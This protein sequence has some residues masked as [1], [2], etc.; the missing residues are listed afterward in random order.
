MRT[1]IF[2]PAKGN[3]ERIKNKNIF[4]LDGMPLFLITLDKIIKSGLFDEV[5]LDSESPEIHKMAD[6]LNCLRLH[7]DPA[8]ATNAADGNGMFLN[9]VRH[10]EADIIV[11]I[12]C[13]SPFIAPGTLKKGLDVLMSGSEY[14]S[15]VLVRKDKRYEWTESGPGYDCAHIPNSVDLPWIYSETMG[16]YM[17][18][19]EAALKTG[20]RIGEKPYL[21]EASP[22]EAVD[23]NDPED[24]PLAEAIA[25]G[26]R[27]RARSR[28]AML[29]VHFSSP[30][31]SDI[32]DDLGVRGVISSLK[33]N[34]RRSRILGRAFTLHLRPLRSG[35][36]YSGIYKTLESYNHITPGDVIMVQND[37]PNYA[38][39][40][41]LN[42]N[43]AVKA[44]AA[45]A[46]IGGMTRDSAAVSEI[47]FPVF[48][49]GVCCADVRKRATCDSYGKKIVINGIEINRG[50]LIFADREGVIV[51]P[52][53]WEAR[54]LERALEAFVKE[55]SII[56]NIMSSQ[57]YNDLY[58][59]FGGF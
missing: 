17:V 6:H 59:R 55:H 7:R 19:R 33:P 54:I 32:M 46:V 58:S 37:C 44:G 4:N 38:Y 34:L 53:E 10:T 1:A 14:D 21:L 31:L 25:A 27:E 48:A 50:D 36:D 40:G 45:G 51:F 23:L 52:F 18:R 16:L 20:R 35:E 12:L 2:L 24:L 56:A 13:T 47:G 42:A 41:E 43:M 3:S 28:F 57:N 26:M 39:F 9:E 5:W 30:M 49:R 29:A 11:Q 8:L 22:L 15:V